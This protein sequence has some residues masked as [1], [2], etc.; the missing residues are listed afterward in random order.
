MEL[1]SD[2][3]GNSRDDNKPIEISNTFGLTAQNMPDILDLSEFNFDND[4]T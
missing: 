1:S 3:M 4:E 2:L